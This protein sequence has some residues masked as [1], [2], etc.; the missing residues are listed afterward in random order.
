MAPT[1]LVFCCFCIAGL[2]IASGMIVDKEL[3]EK[4]QMERKGKE[5]KGITPENIEAADRLN[6]T[7]KD[8]QNDGNNFVETE[9]NLPQSMR[10][11]SPYNLWPKGVVY[12][13]IDPVFNE[14]QTIMITKGITEIERYTCI[15]FV[16]KKPGDGVSNW[17]DIVDKDGCSSPVGMR[18]GRQELSLSRTDCDWR[19]PGTTIH[20]FVH[21]LGFGHEQT[22]PDRDDW[23]EI[24]WENIEWYK[25]KSMAYNFKKSSRNSFTLDQPYDYYSIMHYPRNAFSKN[26]QPTITPKYHVEEHGPCKKM[27]QNCGLTETD[28]KQINILYNCDGSGDECKDIQP[29]SWCQVNISYCRNP[30]VRKYCKESCGD[31]STSECMDNESAIWYCENNQQYG[32]CYGHHQWY[33]S[34]NCRRT[35]GIC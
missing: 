25:G 14:H 18:G 33:F 2:W 20:E 35:C 6:L 15:R 29:T 3:M 34:E 1:G 32:G 22:R 26:G 31:C 16:M 27:G 9:V 28:V 7:D 4:K 24:N 17:V 23:V 5:W 13:E 10:E 12:F 11:I 8:Y 30:I 19:N 21:A